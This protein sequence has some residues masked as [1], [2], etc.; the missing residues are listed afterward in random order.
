MLSYTFTFLA[1]CTLVGQADD[2]APENQDRLNEIM[3]KM[4]G[5][6]ES[7][8]FLEPGGS[9]VISFRWE[10]QKQIICSKSVG[11][12]CE[13]GCYLVGTSQLLLGCS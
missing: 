2:P 6:W 10:A 13:W 7:N 9:C 1:A 11:S 5:V 4:I 3:G 12:Q 8:D